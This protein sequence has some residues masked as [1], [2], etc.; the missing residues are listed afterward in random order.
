MRMTATI[1]QFKA[2]LAEFGCEC[3]GGQRHVLG[4]TYYFVSYEYPYDTLIWVEET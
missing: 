2:L 4:D 3:A 1:D